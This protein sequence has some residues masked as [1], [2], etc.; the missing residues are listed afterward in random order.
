MLLLGLPYLTAT[1]GFFL[2]V[3]VT[4]AALR[5]LRLHENIASLFGVEIQLVASMTLLL[6]HTISVVVLDMTIEYDSTAL[7]GRGNPSARDKATE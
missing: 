3:N 1:A 6:L 7:P 4:A 5:S 2:A